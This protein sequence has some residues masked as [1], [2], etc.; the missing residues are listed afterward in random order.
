M[1]ARAAREAQTAWERAAAYADKLAERSGQVVPV[2]NVR[3]LQQELVAPLGNLLRLFGNSIASH[4][5]QHMRPA[6]F[7][8][9][10]EELPKLNEGVALIDRRLEE[11]LKVC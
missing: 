5:P 2:E 3:A 8:A 11:L 6:F 1:L 9:Y 10:S 7:A 4:L